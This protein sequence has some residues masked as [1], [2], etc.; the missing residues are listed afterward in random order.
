MKGIATIIVAMVLLF[1]GAARADT[2][3]V[4]EEDLDDFAM[5]MAKVSELESLFVDEEGDGYGLDSCWLCRPAAYLV[6]FQHGTTWTATT[7]IEW[8]PED[9]V[10]KVCWD[11][12]LMTDVDG[13]R[14]YWRTTSADCCDFCDWDDWHAQYRNFT[15]TESWV[16][17]TYDEDCGRIIN[18]DHIWYK[19]DERA[20]YNDFDFNLTTRFRVSKFNR[21][22]TSTD[23]KLLI[24]YCPE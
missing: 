18:T 21:T 15:G 14:T 22:G 2:W 7:D 23:S 12:D 5:E 8:D 11:E 1:C 9:A 3:T 24:T 20:Y 17:V 4:A 13:V 6:Y 19:G 10:Y 16:N